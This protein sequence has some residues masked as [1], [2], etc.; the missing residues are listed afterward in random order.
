MKDCIFCGAVGKKMTRGH[1]IGQQIID[2]LPKQPP[3]VPLVQRIF[4]LDRPEMSGWESGTRTLSL[5]A[6]CR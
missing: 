3:G 2:A 6:T 1:I 4:V 5:H